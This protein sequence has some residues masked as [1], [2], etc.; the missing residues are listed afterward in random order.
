MSSVRAAAL[1]P[2]PLARSNS[3]VTRNSEIR[4]V[5]CGQWR[6]L[7][8]KARQMILIGEA[9]HLS[10]P[11]C[12]SRPR[13]DNA[14]FR[15]GAQHRQPR[16]GDEIVD[17]SGDENRLAGA[18]KAGHAEAQRAAAE[19]IGKAPRYGAGFIEKV[20]EKRQGRAST[21]RDVI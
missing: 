4:R 17:E 3:I 10:R 8:D 6:P 18:G 1:L 16:V 7:P 15:R 20:V 2:Q 12:G 13:P 5:D 19:I 14:A 21:T 9:R 11:G